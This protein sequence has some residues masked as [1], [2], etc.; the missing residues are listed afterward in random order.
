MYLFLFVFLMLLLWNGNIYDILISSSCY[1]KVSQTGCLVNNRNLFF[2]VS[3]LEVWDQDAYIIRFWWEGSLPGCKPLTSG[4]MVEESKLSL[5]PFLI[6]ALFAFMR[7]LPS[8]LNSLS[9]TP[10]PNMIALVIRFST[11][12]LQSITMAYIIF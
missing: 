12:N 4:L 8:W 10:P 5:W 3:K 6:R 1:D 11:G 7:A 2:M 9:K